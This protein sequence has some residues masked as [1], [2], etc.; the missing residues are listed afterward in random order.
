M[1]TNPLESLDVSDQSTYLDCNATTPMEPAVSDM[2]VRFMVQEYGNAGSRTHGYGARAKKA[3]QRAR[4][5]VADVVGSKSD[6][7]IFTS[8]ATEANNLA[9]LGLAEHG[10]QTG[11]R[12]IVST[13]IE[14][15]AILQPLDAL[16]RRGFEIELI[17]STPGGWVEPLTLA[18]A[19]REDTLLVSVMDVNNETGVIQPIPE[20]CDQ[21]SGHAA[22]LHVDGAQ[23]FGKHLESLRNPRIDL[24]SVSSHKI[25]GPKGVGA[26]I[27]RRRGFTPLPLTPLVYGG[28]QERGLRAGTLP[29]P[30]IAA[31]GLAAEF[32]KKNCKKRHA[33]CLAYR[34]RVLEALLPL[35][36]IINGD[37]ERT[38]PHTLNLSF[39]GLD[40]EA[41]MVALKDVIAISNGSACTSQSYEPSHVLQAMGLSEDT[42]AG[43][44]RI[45]WSH[46]TR[47]PDWSEV[48]DALKLVL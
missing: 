25:F 3:V 4:R 32:A 22:F 12:H 44:L 31:F 18:S 40:S 5:Q 26:L 23:G 36:P 43:A 28:G 48:T 9:L 19:V 13:A 11:K 6:H 39:P 45:S 21:L 35:A 38:V 33:A 7:V 42:I 41:A 10:R 47:G 2:L 14:H 1:L 17:A 30:L 29:V 37:P 20:I 24:I 46:R 8:G 16:A 34:E 27:A 15:K